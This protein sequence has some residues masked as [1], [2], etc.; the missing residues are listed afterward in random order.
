MG[1]EDGRG[2]T[3]LSRESERRAFPG[4]LGQLV[5]VLDRDAE[6]ACQRLDRLAAADV[7]ARVDTLDGV[8]VQD[9]GELLSLLATLLVERPEPVVA[10]P[11]LTLP[12]DG[13]T[14]EEN[15]SQA[16]VSCASA[17]STARSRS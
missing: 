7:R 2:G 16:R 9:V 4:A 14:D 13:V 10:V 17:L 5:A 6:P 3:D 15:F 11:L 12:G 8:R 1:A